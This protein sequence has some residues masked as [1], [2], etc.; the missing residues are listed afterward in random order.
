MKK[1]YSESGKEEVWKEKVG[2]RTAPV[3]KK[4]GAKS[5]KLKRNAKSEKPKRP[6]SAYVLF[7]KVFR[8]HNAA[9]KGTEA[10]KQAAAAWK[11][12]SDAKQESYKRDAD[13][14]KKE[15]E[16]LMKRYNKN[17]SEEDGKKSEDEGETDVE[18]AI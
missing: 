13:T 3:D 11:N 6:A 18:A 17:K 15:Y 1:A 2:L 14:A 8:E 7:A 16:K 9:L 4:L 12:L 10:S 5:E